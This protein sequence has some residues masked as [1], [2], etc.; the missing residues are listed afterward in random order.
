MVS[1][2]TPRRQRA[3]Q[4]AVGERIVL[5]LGA[6]SGR[7]LEAQDFI[8]I[9][10]RRRLLDLLNEAKP[11]RR[12]RAAGRPEMLDVQPG[13]SHDAIFINARRGEGKTTFLTSILAQLEDPAGPYPRLYSLGIID[14]TLIETKQH[15][16]I[17][18][19]DRLKAAV[20]YALQIKAPAAGDRYEQ[21]QQSLQKL[22]PGLAMLDGIGGKDFYGEDWMD[23]EFILSQGLSDARSATAFELELQNYISLARDCLRIDNFVLAID[24]VDTWFE[25]GWPVL[26]AVRKY[27]TSPYLQIV[28][29]GDL[30]IYNLL[31]RSKQW[32]QL[33]DTFLSAERRLDEAHKETIRLRR[34]AD[35]V[36]ELQDQYLIKVIRPERRI[37]LQPLTNFRDRLEIRIRA[38]G[39]DT[40]ALTAPEFAESYC[41]RLLATESRQA[42][43]AVLDLLLRLPVRSALQVMIAAADLVA[44]PDDQEV[45]PRF[46]RQAIDGLRYV[47]WTDLMQLGLSPEETRSLSPRMLTPLLARWF[48]EANQWRSLPRFHP[49]AADT[50]IDLPALF[51]SAFVTDIFR[52]EPSRMFDYLLRISNVRELVDSG[53]LLATDQAPRNRQLGLVLDHL[54]LMT[55]EDS[56]QTVSRLAAWEVS[57]GRNVRPGVYF[58]IASVP[59]DR[60]RERLV[61]AWD[62][63]GVD[64][65]ADKVTGS[66]RD[67]ILA[68]E[69][70]L[71]TVLRRFHRTLQEGGW[72]YRDRGRGSFE[73]G[74]VNSISG[75]RRRLSSNAV[76][77][78]GLPAFEVVSGQAKQQGG[79]SFLRLVAAVGALAGLSSANSDREELE[80]A[81]RSFLSQAALERSYPT[82]ATDAGDE[83]DDL[84][85]SDF[86]DD[87]VIQAAS[88]DD[89]FSAD[90]TASALVEWIDYWRETIPVAPPLILSRIWSR[91]R[92]AHESIRR[93]LRHRDTRY[94]GVLM[95]RSS[96]AFLHA[97]LVETLRSADQTVSSNANNNPVTAPEPF[98]A[99]LNEVYGDGLV[100]GTHAGLFDAIFTCPLWAFFLPRHSDLEWRRL[101]NANETII[102]QYDQRRETHGLIPSERFC[103]VMYGPIGE[104][105]L[106]VGFDGLYDLLNTVQ[107]QGNPKKKPARTK[108]PRAAT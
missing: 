12:P 89:G 74:L 36:D 106:Q 30:D 46:R 62:L 101:R 13:R 42:V 63:Y 64:E 53:E 99:L 90:A 3:V 7:T 26:E 14:P 39:G 10:A 47:A 100:D 77:V 6:A 85:N 38:A 54:G 102:S 43:S 86:E 57:Q 16:V 70:K 83:V 22:A 61:A 79:Y 75:L 93:Q 71:P 32:T 96:I 105:G 15:I 73:G 5:D 91:F 76:G 66:I 20:D 107:L 45:D 56:L 18:V 81:V 27:L 17:I 72:E 23:S 48:T 84:E 95:H 88:E 59:V 50:G 67:L 29:S 25:R 87:D 104:D 82:P 4:P 52:E 8:Q 97:V 33:G 40:V 2:N 11:E 19:I 94:L 68:D 24:D 9:D 103:R 65:T 34:I 35:K 80:R 49:E 92:Y 60:V 98:V 58:S 51:G 28:L 44:A 31:V 69:N 37:D 21:F 41:R 1:A 108:A 78:V 55:T